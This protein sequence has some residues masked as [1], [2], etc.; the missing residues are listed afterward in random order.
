MEFKAVIFDLGGVIVN[1][2][3]AATIEAFG[4]LGYGDF[5]SVYS[6]AQQTGLI[7]DLETGIISSQRFVNELLPYLKVG[8]SPNKVIAAWNAMIGS[9]PP[10]RLSLLQIVR[11][12]CPIYLL[13]N[14]NDIHMQAILRSWKA[15]SS[16]PMGDFFDGIY[17]SYKIGMCKPDV[18]IFEFICREN[19]L[20]PSDTLFIDDSIQHIEGARLAGLQT[21]HLTHFDSLDQLFS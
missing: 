16:Q 21:I 12:K 19:Q 20:N 11:Q 5:Q 6:Q 14:T 3:Y 17:L 9:V 13:S 18:E 4:T 7:N 2:D 15:S 10:E 1:I 8:T